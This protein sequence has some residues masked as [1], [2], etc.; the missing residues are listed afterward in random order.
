[1][2]VDKGHCIKQWG[3][4]YRKHYASL[5]TLRSFVPRGVPVLAIS[6]TMP[7]TTL[8]NGAA[9]ACSTWISCGVISV[10]HCQLLSSRTLCSS[11]GVGSRSRA[12]KTVTVHPLSRWELCPVRWCE[13]RN[14]LLRLSWVVLKFIVLTRFPRS[15]ILLFATFSAAVR[16]HFWVSVTQERSRY[17]R[18]LLRYHRPSSRVRWVGAFCLQDDFVKT[19]PGR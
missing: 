19:P 7:A 18:L 4:E 14:I 5:E 12:M 6:A 8:E 1:M 16:A 17:R 10:L 13:T 2:V 3:S 11:S 9:S 15:S